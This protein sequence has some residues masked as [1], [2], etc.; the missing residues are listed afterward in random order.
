LLLL[1]EAAVGLDD[2]A[3]GQQT[4]FFSKWKKQSRVVQQRQQH[5]EFTQICLNT[6]QWRPTRIDKQLEEKTGTFGEEEVENI[7]QTINQRPAQTRRADPQS[8]NC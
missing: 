1:D 5:M 4:D 8:L 3:V 6:T 7:L 2:A